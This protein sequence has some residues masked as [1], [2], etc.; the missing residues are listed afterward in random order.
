[1]TY[2]IRVFGGILIAALAALVLCCY[3]KRAYEI[4]EVV[5]R[6]Q[7]MFPCGD[8]PGIQTTLTLYSNQT[9]ML[10]SAYQ[11]R[12]ETLTTKGL[13]RIRWF[14]PVVDLSDS[15]E[16]FYIL[17][18]DTLELLG[19]DGERIQ[20]RFNYTIKKTNKEIISTSDPSF[21]SSDR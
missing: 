8:C 17:D 2:S 1:M 21:I 3:M 12:N 10:V 18:K 15:E 11:D 20:S 6:Y 5:G 19:R 16:R 7:G 9:Y 13:W 4:Q 14:A